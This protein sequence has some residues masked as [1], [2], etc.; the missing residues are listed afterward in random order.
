MKKIPTKSR[1][2]AHIEDVN[3]ELDRSSTTFDD[4][5]KENTLENI[6]PEAI[7]IPHIETSG[8]DVDSNDNTL[9]KS[10]VSR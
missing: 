4:D 6:I 1:N 9:S 5:T 7:Y 2:V 8:K 3:N 10:S